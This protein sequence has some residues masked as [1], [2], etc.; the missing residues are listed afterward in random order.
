MRVR[1][2]PM[3]VERPK[4]DVGSTYA[5]YDSGVDGG[6]SADDER[7]RKAQR[8]HSIRMIEHS[9]TYEVL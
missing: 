5:E 4:Y 6:D 2:R 8:L 3:S 7:G 9:A 1:A